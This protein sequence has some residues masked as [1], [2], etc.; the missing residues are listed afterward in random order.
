[1]VLAKC[2]EYSYSLVV[3]GDKLENVL[4][5]MSSV[6]PIRYRYDDEKGLVVLSAK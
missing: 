2:Y 1:M 4:K 3:K 5:S 6:S